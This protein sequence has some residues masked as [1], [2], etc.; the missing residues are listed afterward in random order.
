MTIK[1]ERERQTNT[2]NHYIKLKIKVYKGEQ[3]G[4]ECRRRFLY[5]DSHAIT[6]R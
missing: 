6:I 4:G 5:G 1:R 3:R 2:K